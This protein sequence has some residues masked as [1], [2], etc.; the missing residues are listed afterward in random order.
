MMANLKRIFI[1]SRAESD[2]KRKCESQALSHR[3]ILPIVNRYFGGHNKHFD[4]TFNVYS[5]SQEDNLLKKGKVPGKKKECRM[6]L[7]LI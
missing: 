7:W 2:P 6:E 5:V 1:R 3:P 4:I